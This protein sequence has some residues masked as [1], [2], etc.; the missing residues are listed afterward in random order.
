MKESG[1]QLKGRLASGG[2]WLFAPS[3]TKGFSSGRTS[4]KFLIGI[5]G[6]L[7]PFN[8]FVMVSQLPATNTI[9]VTATND[10]PMSGQFTLREAITQ[11]NAETGT[12]GGRC[13]ADTGKD[14]INFT[15]SNSGLN[16]CANNPC[17]HGGLCTPTPAGPVC[18][19]AYCW[20]GSQCDTPRDDVGLSACGD[21]ITV[22]TLSDDSTS[23]DGLCSLRKAI[24]NVN[25]FVPGYDGQDTTG[26]DCVFFFDP[27]PGFST[28]T[29]NFSVSGPILLSSAL[30]T[31]NFQGN[32]FPRG[33]ST[34]LTIDGTGQAIQVDGANK[35]G[36]L[37]VSP[38]PPITFNAL[39]I[40][41]GNNSSGS[42]G[43]INNN[44]TLTVTNSTLSS[45]SANN[46]GGIAN[47]STLTI[48]NSTLFGNSASNI[49]GGIFND[50]GATLGMT[51]STFSGNG[52]GGGIY[53]N[54]SATGVTITNT[55]LANSGSGANC[56]GAGVTDGGYNIADD[57]SC[58]FGNSTAA[59][60]QTIG[61]SVSDANIELGPLADNGGPTYTCSL[62]AGSYAIDA[63]P[64]SNNT[65]PSTD[66]RGAPRPGDPANTACDVG[67]FESSPTPTPS[68]SATPST[69]PSPSISPSPNT[70]PSPTATATSTPTATGTPTVTETATTTATPTVTETPTRT[71]TPT[72][73]PSPTVS[74]SSTPT[75]TGTPTAAMTMT[76]SPTP[77]QTGTA[78]GTE[79]A[80]LTPTATPTPS[81]E[82]FFVG[83]ASYFQSGSAV[84]S[85]TLTS[86]GE[87]EIGDVL[88]AQVV[89]YDAYGTNVPTA[90][91]GWTLIR[92]DTINTGNH[93]TSWIYSR[94][95]GSASS[96]NYTWTISSSYAT[97][98][99]GTW[100]WPPTR[101]RSARPRARLR[102]VPIR[103]PSR[104]PR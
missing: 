18:T 50:T 72:V 36:V 61:D 87:T 93:L 51:N 24:D 42:G 68:A 44:G 40:Q 67:A 31:I 45:N 90:P 100:R 12:S 70:S 91:T 37:A 83:A 34:S 29:L 1:L 85:I 48:T 59:N 77:T 80:T 30:P 7:L 75:A 89:V 33:A 99:L 20:V 82:I 32:A 35:Y 101:S 65:C 2:S 79:T 60:D 52:A 21:T 56:A 10:T 66:Q 94:I 57:A 103:L 38:G 69:S 49:G 28:Y 39:T 81:S 86:D 73:T 9:T 84:T 3:W 92:K 58:G 6:L 25:A 46:G 97:G 14:L 62:G 74:P 27:V 15:P 4:I 19:C 47:E 76:P 43:G 17:L 22:N 5:V 13:V 23:G 26:G 41:N 98:L 63:I 88:L 71:G 104:R 95:A 54:G 55:I 53:N 16:V 102:V 11:A 96:V 8:V 78:T 64:T